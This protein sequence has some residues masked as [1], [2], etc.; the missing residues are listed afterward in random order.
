LA[1][2][3]GT[4]FIKDGT[5]EKE[6][7][8]D[9]DQLLSAAIVY[10]PAT[11]DVSFRLEVFG[12]GPEPAVATVR[13]L[14]GSKP[15]VAAEAPVLPA[16]EAAPPVTPAVETAAPPAAEAQ[17]QATEQPQPEESTAEADQPPTDAAPATMAAAPPRSDIPGAERTR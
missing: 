7:A 17:P 3:R 10:S 13:L 8:L 1:A 6:L 2:K 11:T 9:R 12:A 15:E 5:F 4:L 16:P 14:A